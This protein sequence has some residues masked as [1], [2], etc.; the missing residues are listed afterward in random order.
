MEAAPHHQY[1]PVQRYQLHATHKEL[2]ITADNISMFQ[3]VV[4]IEPYHV[5]NVD[6]HLNMYNLLFLITSSNGFL[7]R[8]NCF[9]DI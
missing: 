5:L 3:N 2:P 7:K 6:N 4:E 8:L 1:L 9:L